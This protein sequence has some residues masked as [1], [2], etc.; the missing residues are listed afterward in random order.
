MYKRQ[1]H[2]EPALSEEYDQLVGCCFDFR[3]GGRKSPKLEM[4]VDVDTEAHEITKGSAAFW[5]TSCED[6]FCNMSWLEDVPVTVLATVRDDLK[7]YQDET[8]I[9]EH[10]KVDF[11]NAN[12]EELPGINTDQPVAWVHNYGEGRVFTVSIG[13]GPDTLRRMSFVGMVCRATEWVASGEITIPYPDVQ[14]DK[15]F[16]CWPYYMDMSIREFAAL[17]SF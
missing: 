2:G 7:D 5:M 4:I 15:R 13:H 14:G 6:F 12:L 17:T 10:R 8:K 11:V 3:K 16:R 9:Q 1:I